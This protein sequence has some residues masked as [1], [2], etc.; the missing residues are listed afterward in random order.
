MTPHTSHKAHHRA[1]VVTAL[2]VEYNAVRAHLVDISANVRQ[3]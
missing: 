1:D 2:P 3:L